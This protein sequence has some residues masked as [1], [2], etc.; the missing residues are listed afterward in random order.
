MMDCQGL[1]AIVGQYVATSDGEPRKT[2]ST[3]KGGLTGEARATELPG[4]VCV[5]RMAGRR[6]WHA[7]AC[8]SCGYASRFPFCLFRQQLDNQHAD[9]Q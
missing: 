6:S 4:N 7:V 2:R 3:R 1:S 8:C 9:K 5:F